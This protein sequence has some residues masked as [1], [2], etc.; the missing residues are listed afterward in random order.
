MLGWV[1]V[2]SALSATNLP[3]VARVLRPKATSFLQLG[4][5]DILAQLDQ[6]VN[7][8][9][10][11]NQLP[12][13]ERVSVEQGMKLIESISSIT[14]TVD[15]FDDDL[16]K[17]EEGDKRALQ[18]EIHD[19]TAPFLSDLSGR[20][21]E[22]PGFGPPKSQRD[23]QSLVQSAQ[24]VIEPG[25]N[26]FDAPTSMQRNPWQT[27]K[28]LDA[29]DGWREAI[30]MAKVMMR[31]DVEYKS[32][33]VPG[34]GVIRPYIV[35]PQPTL[36]DTLNSALSAKF[37]GA[38]GFPGMLMNGVNEQSKTTDNEITNDEKEKYAAAFKELSEDRA[39]RREEN[40]Q[41]FNEEL[42]ILA[43]GVLG[44]KG[45]EAANMLTS[46]PA[47]AI[48]SKIDQLVELIPVELKQMIYATGEVP[49]DPKPDFLV[50]LEAKEKEERM[51]SSPRE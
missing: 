6:D 25:Q 10:N 50:E 43:G 16:D 41:H 28:F 17:E 29:Y 5:D 13:S 7:G 49:K 48:K 19:L 23:S 31:P 40:D 12:P 38:M 51:R 45:K 15:S 21:F 36:D 9:G 32:L 1:V 30:N 20:T 26:I 34:V 42:S 22:Q 27:D 18:R 37:G 47:S 24:D 44:D 3:P 14:K 2:I 11:A 39:I 4:Q 46:G 33:F 35:Y 8:A